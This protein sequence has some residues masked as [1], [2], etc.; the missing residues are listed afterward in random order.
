VLAHERSR[1]GNVAR[2]CHDPEVWLGVEHQLKPTPHDPVVLG[3]DDPH[4][5]RAIGAAAIAVIW[6]D[7]GRP[8]PYPAAAFASGRP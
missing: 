3:E 2:L 4:N 8:S 6:L 7:H 5:P 1:R